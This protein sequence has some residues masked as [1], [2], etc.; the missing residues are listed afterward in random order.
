MAHTIFRRGDQKA[1]ALSTT[2]KPETRFSMLRNGMPE[3]LGSRISIHASAFMSW[4][5]PPA[6]SKVTWPYY[7]GKA[8]KQ[9]LYARTFQKGDKPLVYGSILNEYQKARPFL[10]LFPMV[11]GAGNQVKK[12]STEGSRLHKIVEDA[13]YMLI[14]QAMHVNPALRNIRDRISLDRFVIDGTPRSPRRETADAKRFRQMMGFATSDNAVAAVERVIGIS[15]SAADRE[16]KIEKILEQVDPK[17]AEAEPFPEAI[18]VEHAKAEN[19][20]QNQENGE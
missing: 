19:E 6:G 15:D 1:Y 2:L 9:T 14:G 18:D 5:F 8:S 17:S 4:G 11:T 10:Y 20:R 12:P 7:V 3:G 13:E 16:S